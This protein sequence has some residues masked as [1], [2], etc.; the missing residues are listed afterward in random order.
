MTDAP[1]ERPLLA[2]IDIGTNSVRMSLVR[3]DTSAHTWDVVAEFKETV[4]LGQ[5][6]FASNH[7]SEEAIARGV[8]VLNQFAQIASG[9]GA[10]EVVAIG[11]AALRE[12]QNREDFIERAREAAGIEVQ[13]VSGVEEAR[14]IYL[15][16]ASGIEL[17]EKKALF[18]DIG[19]GSTELI[20]G[21]QTEHLLLESLKLG[22]I[23]LGNRFLSDLTGPVPPALMETMRQYVRGVGSHALRKVRDMGFETAVASSGTAMNLAKIAAARA[24]LDPTA[25]IRNFHLP[26]AELADITKML[27]RLSVEERRKVP[28]LNPERADIIVSGASVLTTIAEELDI[29]DYVISDRS[30]REGVLVDALQRRA[31]DNGPG[32]GVR[33]RSIER[34]FRLT[35]KEEGHARHVAHLT[36]SL[37]DQ[38][39]TLG[40]HDYGPEERELLEYAALLHDI[41]VFIS[42]SGHHRHSYYLIRHSELAGFTDEE[43]QIIANLAYFHRKSAPKKRH[44]HFQSL[45]REHQRLVRKLAALL[46]LSESLDRSQLGLVREV[47]A[48]VSGRRVVLSLE[49]SG[50]SHLETWY[51]GDDV[52]AFEEAYGLSLTLAEE[53]AAISQLRVE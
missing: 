33:R 42:R 16:V 10:H 7:L 52:G 14:L 11:T 2:A 36:L 40:L 5:D 27:S 38:L 19:G 29:E 44:L 32:A 17:G 53:P 6:E 4:R 22:A 46:R 50:D 51:I 12:A 15:G 18:V 43:I 30:L 26:T 21:T 34:L 9:H 23:R 47:H 8:Q 41:G 45:S 37:F 25:S 35:E 48:E 31:P 1:A 28:G 13:V 3:L 24:G 39:R 20:V 49:T